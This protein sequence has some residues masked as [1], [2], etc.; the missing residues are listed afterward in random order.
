MEEAKDSKSPTP[1]IVKLT[2]NPNLLNS[3]GKIDNSTPGS[4]S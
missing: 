2:A 1:V 4:D 3:H